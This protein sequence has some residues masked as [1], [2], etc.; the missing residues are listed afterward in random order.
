MHVRFFY[1]QSSFLIIDYNKA[2]FL[3]FLKLSGIPTC[4]LPQTL[5]CFFSFLW[6]IDPFFQGRGLSLIQGRSVSAF[7]WVC[8]LRCWHK[9]CEALTWDLHLHPHPDILGMCVFMFIH[10]LSC[11]PMQAYMPL[12]TCEGLSDMN[13]GTLAQDCSAWSTTLWE[14]AL[15]LFLTS[16]YSEEHGF[17]SHPHH[18]VKQQWGWIWYYII[19]PSCPLICFSFRGT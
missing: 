14:T 17:L 4:T 2:C 8:S 5:S 16:D 7:G 19:K 1:N 15:I 13:I 12:F 18:V 11:K 6:L 3:H 9:L 10:N